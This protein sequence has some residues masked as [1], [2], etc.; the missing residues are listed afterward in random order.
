MPGNAHVGLGIL[1]DQVNL[2]GQNPLAGSNLRDVET[3]FVGMTDAYTPYLR[4]LARGVADD[5]GISVEEGVYAGTLGP[6]FETP[7]EIGMLRMLGVSYVG[8]S[9][10]CEVIM[11]HALGM[12]VLG[13]TLA[14][15]ESG[16]ATVTHE[17][18]LA[19][20]GRHADDFERLVRGVLHLL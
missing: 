19:E 12:N 5:L 4:T 7:A 9:T 16:D 17:S 6:T 3:P 8:M 2:T 1:T 13:L 14:A 15:N 10:V 20:A 18:V 11:A